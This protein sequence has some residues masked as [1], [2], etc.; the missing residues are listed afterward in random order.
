MPIIA[1]TTVK[2]TETTIR[3]TGKNLQLQD[4]VEDEFS[5]SISYIYVA[6][7]RITPWWLQ[8]CLDF[9]TNVS[10]LQSK[11]TLILRY[12]SYTVL[13]KTLER[14]MTSCRISLQNT[15]IISILVYRISKQL[16]GPHIYILN[17]AICLKQSWLLGDWVALWHYMSLVR[18][19]TCSLK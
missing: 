2:W 9:G 19:S 18:K 11:A 14:K 13:N 16:G 4:Q 17:I 5:N 10:S 6:P 8:I 15:A 3:K 1:R 7:F 12:L